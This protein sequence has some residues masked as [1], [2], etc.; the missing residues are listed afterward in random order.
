MPDLSISMTNNNFSEGQIGAT[1]VITINNI[2]AAATN[3]LV[4]LV[5]T[6]PQG[7]SATGMSGAGWNCNVG[8]VTCARSDGLAAGASYPAITLTMNVAN[9]APGQLTSVAVVSGG[10]ENN[11]TNDTFTNPTIIKSSPD[12]AITLDHLG[13]F[14]QGQVG[15][16]YHI[17]VS[18]AGQGGVTGTVSVVDSLPP[19]L[20]A[21]AISGVGWTCDLGT[22]VCTRSD[23]VIPSQAYP[24]ITLTVNVALNA[25]ASVTNTATVSGGGEINLANDVANDVATVG[26]VVPDLSISK[27]HTGNFIPG[28]TT[29]SNATYTIIVTNIGVGSTTVGSTITVVDTLP[30]SLTASSISGAGWNCTLASL[31]CTR[32]DAQA[33]AS[34]YPPITIPVT[35]AGLTPI[36]FTNVATVSGGGEVNTANDSA[37]DFTSVTLV[38]DMTIAATIA[39]PGSFLKGQT[40]AQFTFSATN[41]GGGSTTGA[42]NVV[43]VLP[44]ELTATAIAGTG[45]T[46]TLGTLT[47]IRADVLQ[48]GQSYP[49][50]I[51]TMNVAANPPSSVSTTA[52]VSG[53]GEI[54]VSNDVFTFATTITTPA[55]V[56]LSA[57]SLSF[58]NQGVNTTKP[59]SKSLSPIVAVKRSHLL[60]SPPH[61]FPTLQIGQSLRAQPAPMELASPQAANA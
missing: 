59:L 15:A 41:S 27:T 22:L 48:A 7:L 21:T 34:S 9:N 33:P 19:G 28:Q 55:A 31:T 30:H 16:I 26:G 40:G 47:C 6:L 23:G 25:P 35:V 38:P 60:V 3:S 8:T 52:T 43:L 53:G 36:T 39:P 57:T 50:I 18:N 11:L 12:L 32:V 2:G 49:G 46:C 37:S 51:V 42:V 54:N 13:N 10:G 1:Y 61:C 24:A 29:G 17:I 20:T 45:W 58:P 14:S 56:S 4:S 44:A 5:D